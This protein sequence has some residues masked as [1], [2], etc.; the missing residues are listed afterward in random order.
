MPLRG[1]IAIANAKI[2]YEQY[3]RFVATDRWRAVREKGAKPQRLL[4]GSTSA[5]DPTYPL[6]YYVEALIGRDTVD[7][8]TMD[9]LRGYAAQGQP[10]SRL[11]RDIERAHDQITMLRALEIDLR[12]ITQTLEAEGVKAFSDSYEKALSAIGRKLR[13]RSPEAT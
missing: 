13:P 3:G 10:E 8:M 1:K 6:L 12:S 11:D 4:W 7:T 5:K 2:A 9:C